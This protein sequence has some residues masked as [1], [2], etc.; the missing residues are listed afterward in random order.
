[1]K[2]KRILSLLFLYIA[3]SNI[4]T[5]EAQCSIDSISTNTLPC[6][7]DKS[8]SLEVEL[9]AESPAIAY[10][11]RANGADYGVYTP[12]QFPV[13]IDGIN[14]NCVTDYTFEVVD[15][16]NPDCS[17]SDHIG[18]ICCDQ[19]CTLELETSQAICEGN[20]IQFELTIVDDGVSSDSISFFL[21]GNHIGKSKVEN[22]KVS[23][24]MS[25][26]E[27]V[28]P[29]VACYTNSDCCDT[30]YVNNPCLCNI[31]N[32]ST[33]VSSCSNS[34]SNYF[35]IVDFD[36][37]SPSSDSFSIGRTNNGLGTFAYSSLPIEVGPIHHTEDDHDIFIIDQTDAFCFG[38]TEH[39]TLDSCEA[40]SCEMNNLAIT[41]S[42]SCDE[43]G[44]ISIEYSFE[45]SAGLERFVLFVDEVAVDTLAYF[46]ESYTAN[47]KANC[48][49]GNRIRIQDINDANCSVEGQVAPVCC[50]C[51][52]TDISYEVYCNDGVV[53]SLTIHFEHEGVLSDSFNLL[54]AGQM[55]SHAYA[56]LP[57]HI[58]EVSLPF[59]AQI[60]DQLYSHCNNTL[61]IS[62]DE[63]QSCAIYELSST[64]LACDLFESVGTYELSFRAKGSD[65]DSVAIYY[66]DKQIVVMPID[67]SDRNVYTI[68][69]LAL[70][71]NADQQLIIVSALSDAS[72][73]STM[74]LAPNCCADCEVDSVSVSTTCVD[75]QGQISIILE[76]ASNPMDSVR[77][78]SGGLVYR[79]LT[80]SDFPYQLTDLSD[81]VYKIDVLPVGCDTSKFSI[82]INCAIESCFDD[83]ITLDTVCNNGL[84]DYELNASESLDQAVL[85]S[86][87]GGT[88]STY[89]PGAFTLNSIVAIDSETYSFVIQGVTDTTCITTF[90]GEVNCEPVSTSDLKDNGIKV[91]SNQIGASILS[92]QLIKSAQL[93][94]INGGL[95]DAKSDCFDLV[96]KSTDYP[97]GLY[98]LRLIL[99]DDSNHVVKLFIP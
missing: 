14:G 8:F 88:A 51:S 74:E 30:I 71:C 24:T 57:I 85:I 80:Q 4:Y 91:L 48:S 66:L 62:S 84:M 90:A 16:S 99:S 17:K 86:I 22:G 60:V 56:D 1:M 49:D 46:Q 53:D 55:I 65:L 10:N 19:A 34:D 72:C 12:D 36:Y 58:Y 94:H 76:G 15:V 21:E 52:L 37:S 73:S 68:N 25:Y 3:I 13:R 31:Y 79:T 9:Y 92:E 20:E 61:S 45:T 27:V 7:I 59:N 6:V 42:E 35:L 64:Q 75:E 33:S 98:A 26:S 5:V 67:T 97:T 50:P 28:V 69:D 96:Y 70:D 81:G 93:Y 11:I 18:V 41:A 54:Y 87:N 23:G 2:G 77:L 39:I 43:A 47:I 82:D 89:G 83:I 78:F 95:L 32:V 38:F 63:C 40:I 44:N 29:L